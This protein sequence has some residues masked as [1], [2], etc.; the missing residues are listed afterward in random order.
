[1]VK[2]GQPTSE[3]NPSI[4]ADQGAGQGTEQAAGPGAEQ[5]AGPGTEQGAG[6]APDQGTAAEIDTWTKRAARTNPA[7]TDSARSDRREIGVNRRGA[8]IAIFVTI[9]VGVVADCVTNLPRRMADRLFATNDDEAYWR[10]WQIIKVHCGSGR[11]YREPRF[12]MLVAC[13]ECKGTG[14]GGIEL[15]GL[16]LPCGI[17]LG[18]GRLTTAEGEPV[19][20]EAK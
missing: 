16:T 9:A 11:R 20:G 3:N 17:C 6:P 12:D 18:A 13:T 10:D 8:R 4:G 5:A 15:A 14:I 7:R 19:A 1:V 2:I